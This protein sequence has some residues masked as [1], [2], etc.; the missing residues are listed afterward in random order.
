MHSDIVAYS[1]SLK[2]PKSSEK[3]ALLVCCSLDLR[4]SLA[5]FIARPV[6]EFVAT[7][8]QW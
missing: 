6:F 3:C 5:V 7:G 1:I 4:I 8:K 2:R